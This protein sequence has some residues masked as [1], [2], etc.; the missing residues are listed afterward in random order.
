MNLVKSFPIARLTTAF[1]EG[2][3]LI[4]R[5]HEQTR[6]ASSWSNL[7]EAVAGSSLR[8]QRAVR[9]YDQSER[10]ERLAVSHFLGGE[11]Q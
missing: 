5:P 6:R 11:Q 9:V 8:G 7:S 2:A 1:G 10:V 4:R 3:S